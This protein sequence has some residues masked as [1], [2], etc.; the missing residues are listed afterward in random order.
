MPQAQEVEVAEDK[1][2][3]RRGK[4]TATP[5]RRSPR[6][7]TDDAMDVSDGYALKMPPSILKKTPTDGAIRSPDKKKG[8]LGSRPRGRQ[9]GDGTARGRRPSTTPG[10]KPRSSSK[11]RSKTPTGACRPRS[12]SK[13]RTSASDSGKKKPTYSDKA[14]APLSPKKPLKRLKHRKF[15]TGQLSMPRSSTLRQDVYRK[16]CTMLSTAQLVEGAKT[17]R[18]LNHTNIEEKP[19]MTAAQMPSSH[20]E[21]C[22]YFDFPIR[23]KDWNGE[24]IPNG[25]TKSRKI[26]FS[27]LLEADVPIEDIV[28]AVQIDL[29][30]QKITLSVKTC[31]AL[32]HVKR[33]HLM[34]VYNRYNRGQ[35]EKDFQSQLI[36]FQKDQAEEKPDSLLGA[37]EA[38][39]K[40]FPRINVRLDYPFNGPFEKTKDGVDTRYKRTFVI[41]YAEKDAE[42][43]EDAVKLYKRSGKLKAWWGEHAQTHIAPAKD[44]ENVGETQLNQ[45][46]SICDTHSATMLSSGMVRL[47][48][49]KNPDYKV[50]VKFWKP[51][52]NTGQEQEKMSLR[53]VLHSITVP[54]VKKDHQ[55]FHGLI[56]APDG[57]WETAVADTNPLAKA[58][59]RNVATHPA[60]WVLGFIT[61]RGWAKDCISEFMRKTFTTAA[62]VSAQKAKYD[63]RTRQV[64]SEDMDEVEREL[65]EVT[66]SWVDMSLLSAG[67][68]VV[69]E[70]AVLE[71]GNMAA[72]N[73]EDG[74]SVKT[75]GSGGA[76]GN[77]QRISRVQR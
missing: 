4:P 19:L 34:H 22:K 37:L 67:R 70:S 50:E 46:H 76:S 12:R 18:I 73:W 27:C 66:D 6:T 2:G 68:E 7:K 13:T 64:K 54:G 59:A 56:K 1:G 38:A 15:I 51:S 17:C 58:Q 48:H 29:I 69:Q 53:D 35:V 55:V 45:W 9:E 44:D 23:N 62:V 74:A 57:G 63:K 72:F 52:K 32:R 77:L 36:Q 42:H 8:R 40:E 31:Q 33:L 41:K 21:V 49:I 25:P 24:T 10:G 43:V 11:P 61:S 60:G 47:D 75:M 16:V 65:Q 26:E 14:K 20:V 30:E 3:N 5:T 28:D 71:S 39:G